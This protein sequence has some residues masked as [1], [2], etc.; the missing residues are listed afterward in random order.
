MNDYEEE[1]KRLSYKNKRLL[2]YIRVLKK[3]FLGE[4]FKT[5]ADQLDEAATIVMEIKKLY[6]KE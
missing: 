5:P 3:H 2:G 6:P 1:N 4:E